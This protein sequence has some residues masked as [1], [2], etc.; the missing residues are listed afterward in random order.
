M[1]SVCVCVPLCVIE[2]GVGGGGLTE[3]GEKGERA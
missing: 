2:K 3:C 1:F